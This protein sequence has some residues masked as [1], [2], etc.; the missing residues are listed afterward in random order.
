[1]TP[2]TEK[3][4]TVDADKQTKE[5]R[6]AK[7]KQFLQVADDTRELAD[8]ESEIAD[9]AVTL[10]VHAGIAASDV[11]CAKHLGKYSRGE[12]H[13]QAIKLL[14][15]VDKDL[16]RQLKTLL[17]MKTRAGYG[18]SPISTQNLLRATRAAQTLV[19]AA[20]E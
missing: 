16:S 8:E 6:L 14:S 10:Y 18:H 1:M 19:E 20:S 7:A 5:G 4:R 11:I 13:Q 17:D 15:K 9:A 12:N 3:F 2:E